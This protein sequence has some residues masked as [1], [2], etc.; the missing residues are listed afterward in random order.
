MVC[1][2][3]LVWVDGHQGRAC[4]RSEESVTIPCRRQAAGSSKIGSWRLLYQGRLSS[5]LRLRL[6]KTCWDSPFP[7]TVVLQRRVLQWAQRNPAVFANFDWSQARR[8][9]PCKNGGPTVVAYGVWDIANRDIYH[10]I[11]AEEIRPSKANAFQTLRSPAETRWHGIKERNVPFH[12][13][14]EVRLVDIWSWNWAHIV[15]V[16]GTVPRATYRGKWR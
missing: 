7:E 13:P 6:W 10:R 5:L 4:K 2:A 9:I 12:I 1:A 15:F 16:V 8:A 14:P 11:R 3:S